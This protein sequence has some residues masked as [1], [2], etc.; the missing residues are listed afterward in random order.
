MFGS[1]PSFYKALK[2][3]MGPRGVWI[4]AEIPLLKTYVFVN[5]KDETGS[6]A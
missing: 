3:G 2:A 1:A 6:H 5:E 4:E